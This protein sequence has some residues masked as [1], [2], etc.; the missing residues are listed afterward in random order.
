MSN[1]KIEDLKPEQAEKRDFS[2]CDITLKGNE[3][4]NSEEVNN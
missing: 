3:H 2:N 4:L 1:L